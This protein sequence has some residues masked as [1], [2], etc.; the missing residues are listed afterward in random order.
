MIQRFPLYDS[1]FVNTNKFKNKILIMDVNMNVF[2]YCYYNWHW[3][4]NSIFSIHAIPVWVSTLYVIWYIPPF[5]YNVSTVYYN[6]AQSNHVLLLN[7]HIS[8][9]MPT[10]VLSEYVQKSDLLLQSVDI[11]YKILVR[12]LF[13]CI[14]QSF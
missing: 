12:S 13:W 4:F 6:A 7:K 10:V 8:G 11:H 5:Y 14:V 9:N 1:L 3:L 2:K